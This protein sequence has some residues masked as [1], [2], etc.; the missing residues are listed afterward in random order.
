MICAAV[1]GRVQNLL[2]YLLFYRKVLRNNGDERSRYGGKACA[3]SRETSPV[4]NPLVD[5]SRRGGDGVT[6]SSQGTALLLM[7]IWD[8]GL[9]ARW[10]RKHQLH[11][12]LCFATDCDM[13]WVL[14]P[15]GSRWFHSLSGFQCQAGDNGCC[16]GWQAVSWV[17]TSPWATFIRPSRATMRPCRLL[18][19][20]RSKFRILTNSAR[21]MAQFKC[22]KV[23]LIESVSAS[24]HTMH[25][26]TGTDG[27]RRL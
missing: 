23:C 14:L 19:P 5:V 16:V 25:N 24:F 2:D 17:P 18:R 12:S 10:G 6:S 26:Y 3:I 9:G 1:W 7:C 4:S 11:I 27:H 8:L 15:Q 13:I 22:L 21:I 20:T